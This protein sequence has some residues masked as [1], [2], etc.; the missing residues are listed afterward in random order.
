MEK[1]DTKS[2]IKD[3]LLVLQQNIQEFR[4]GIEEI[5]KLNY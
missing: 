2:A 1:Q 3:E 4:K 5:Y